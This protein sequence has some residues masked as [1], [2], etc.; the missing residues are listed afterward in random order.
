MPKSRTVT[1]TVNLDDIR[2]HARKVAKSNGGLES[3]GGV[4]PDDL[5]MAFD[6]MRA[7]LPKSAAALSDVISDVISIINDAHEEFVDD[8]R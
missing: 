5:A 1:I 8:N 2:A 4:T 7:C 6:V 3:S